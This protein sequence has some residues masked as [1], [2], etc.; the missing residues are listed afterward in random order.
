MASFSM[1]V[2][3]LS[4]NAMG[5]VMRSPLSHSMSMGSLLI[6]STL[7]EPFSFS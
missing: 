4:C 1:R 3:I 7:K 6:A 5:V 2:R